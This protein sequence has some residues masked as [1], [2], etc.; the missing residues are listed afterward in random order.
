MKMADLVHANYL[1]VPIMN[2]FG[3]QLGFGDKTIKQVCDTNSVNCN[4]FIE[5]VNAY[6]DQ[7]YYPKFDVDSFPL[8]DALSYLSNSHKAYMELKLPKIEAFL[9]DIINTLADKNHMI[10]LKNFFGEYKQELTAH[11]ERE[12]KV[13][14]PYVLNVFQQFN[15]EKPDSDFV[16][17]MLNYS[18]HDYS[19]E[20]DNVEEK[21]FDLKNIIIK[22]LPP[23]QIPGLCNNL[24]FELFRLERDLNDHTMIE[25]KIVVPMILVM[26]DSIKQRCNL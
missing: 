3:I 1:F 22:Y 15:K 6:H 5:I 10:L 4:F 21:L 2:R 13:V 18:I 14:Y 9:D 7:S 19:N 24:L 23:S 16:E 17:Q 26:E 20:H 8:E 25:E 12:E 11:I